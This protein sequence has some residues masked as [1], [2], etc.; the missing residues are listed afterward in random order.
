MTL[1]VFSGLKAVFFNLIFFLFIII[2]VDANSQ[3]TSAALFALLRFAGVD[4]VVLAQMAHDSL[5]PGTAA[6]V[7]INFQ[8]S[9]ID[10]MTSSYAIIYIWHSIFSSIEIRSFYDELKK[11]RTINS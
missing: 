8:L 11:M 4:Y 6:T 7:A 9:Y 10:R 1:A 5:L 3:F 2:L